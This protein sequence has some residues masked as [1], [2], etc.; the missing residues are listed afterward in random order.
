MTAKKLPEITGRRGFKKYEQNP[1]LPIAADKTKLGVKRISNK[2]GNKCMIISEHGEI[3]APAGFHEIVEVDKT[4][5]VKLYVNG[6]KAFQGLSS[7]GAKLFELVYCIVQEK[8]SVD[9][10]YIHFMNVDQARFPL[11][12]RTFHRGITELLSK[13]FIFESI[14]PNLYFINIDYMFNGNRLAFIKEY[15]FKESGKIKK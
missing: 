3:L 1:S 13:G 7:A 9:K 11:S 6:V 5:F 10:V 2:A 4:Q 15:F 12:E 14:T 8:P